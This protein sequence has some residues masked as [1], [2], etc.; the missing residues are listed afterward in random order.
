MG[1]EFGLIIDLTSAKLG[2]YYKLS[3]EEKGEI[4]VEKI[5]CFGWILFILLIKLNFFNS[6]LQNQKN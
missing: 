5:A 2:R 6:K 1:R 4:Q 3:D